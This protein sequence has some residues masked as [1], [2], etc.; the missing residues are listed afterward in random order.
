MDW[1]LIII[2]LSPTGESI[3]AELSEMP[4]DRCV[5]V[6]EALNA[7]GANLTAECMSQ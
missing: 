2:F 1:L 5:I 7:S 6:A 4:V 3:G